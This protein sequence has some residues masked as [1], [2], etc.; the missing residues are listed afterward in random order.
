L[1]DNTK[2]YLGGGEDGLDGSKADLNLLTVL[3]DFDGVTI[4]DT[5]NLAFK[6]V[7]EGWG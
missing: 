3:E 1:V 4:G 6:G 2:L 7:K 5:N